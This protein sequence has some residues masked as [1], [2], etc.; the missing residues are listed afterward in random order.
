VPSSLDIY[1]LAM[2]VV[3][4]IHVLHERFN[5]YTCN[6]HNSYTYTYTHVVRVYIEYSHLRVL[7]RNESY[8]FASNL[9][10]FSVFWDGLTWQ[11]DGVGAVVGASPISV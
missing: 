6:T 1:V 2:C 5:K 9:P 7:S 10:R 11:I 4:C 8:V 3:V